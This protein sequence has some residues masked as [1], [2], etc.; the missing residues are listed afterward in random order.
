MTEESLGFEALVR[1]RISVRNYAD[2]PVPPEALERCL[3]ASRLAPSA[4]NAQPWMFIVVEDPARRLELAR[5]TV[6]PGGVMNRFVAQAPTLVVVVAERPN[7][8]SQIG[9]LLKNKPFYLIDIGIAAEHFCLQ[10]AALG[11]GTCMIG[12]FAEGKTRALLGIPAGK[13]PVLIIT[14]GYPAGETLTE[15]AQ[16][17]PRRRKTMAEIAATESYGSPYSRRRG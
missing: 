1:R 14:V 17:R 2:R 13:R 5:L 4:C 12:W 8:S 11:L 6:P 15:A 3:E 16:A 9:S 7:I 10:A